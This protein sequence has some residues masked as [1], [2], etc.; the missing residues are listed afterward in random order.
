MK[1]ELDDALL[2]GGAAL[3]AGALGFMTD[4]RSSALF[5]GVFVMYLAVPKTSKVR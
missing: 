1:F 5:L 3:T 4:W 2:V